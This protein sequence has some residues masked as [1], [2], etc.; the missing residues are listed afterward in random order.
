[1]YMRARSA[2]AGSDGRPSVRDRQTVCCWPME[3]DAVSDRHRTMHAASE[4]EMIGSPISI[5]VGRSVGVALRRYLIA[6]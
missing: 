4:G 1:V 2:Q 3:A 6:K 5:A